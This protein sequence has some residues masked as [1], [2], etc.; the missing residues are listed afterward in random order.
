MGLE[1][2]GATGGK[3]AK[4]TDDGT[5]GIWVY[6][7]NPSLVGVAEAELEG[8][9][10]VVIGY[11]GQVPGGATDEGPLQAHGTGGVHYV[12]VVDPDEELGATEVKATIGVDAVGATV[13]VHECGGVNV[14]V[15]VVIDCLV[16]DVPVASPHVKGGDLGVE[17]CVKGADLERKFRGGDEVAFAVDVDAFDRTTPEDGGVGEGGAGQQCGDCCQAQDCMFRF[18]GGGVVRVVECWFTSLLVD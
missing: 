17:A 18:H 3:R 14:H 8:Q 15:G 1:V 9:G 11:G 5:G 10:V 7:T 2:K 6:G 13:G 12:V 16:K 4:V